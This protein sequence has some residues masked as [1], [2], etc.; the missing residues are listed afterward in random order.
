LLL[1]CFGCAVPEKNFNL[2]DAELSEDLR[3]LPQDLRVYVQ[4]SAE[5]SSREVAEYS[6]AALM[7]P[8]RQKREVERARANLF[9]PWVTPAKPLFQGE[10][11]EFFLSGKSLTPQA[12]MWGLFSLKPEKGFAEN[13]R[14]YPADRWE[15][16]RENSAGESFPNSSI[17]AITVRRCDLRLMPTETPY[18]FDPA[19]AGQGYPFDFYQNSTLPLGAPVRVIHLSKDEQWGLVEHSS[20]MGWA[21]LSNLA[22]VDGHFMAAWMD[23]PLAA[24]LREKTPIG[25]RSAG[26]SKASSENSGSLPLVEEAGI[27]ALLPYSISDSKP[28]PCAFELPATASLRHSVAGS[29]SQSDSRTGP[30]VN[31]NYM[32]PS[33]QKQQDGGTITVYF[34]E[35]GADGKA[36]LRRCVLD[37]TEAAPWPVLLTRLNIAGLGNRMLG[38]PYGWGGY[39]GNRDCSSLLRD[40]FLPFGLWL[41]RNS[42]AQAEYG[43]VT[44][45]S[46]LTAGAKE[47]AILHQGR[48]FLSLIGL[49]G[50]IAL[51]VGR[52]KNRA[53]I[54]HALWGLRTAQRRSVFGPQRS[55][56]LIIGKTVVTTVT[57]GAEKENIATPQSL[58]DLVNSMNYL[59]PEEE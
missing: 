1:V 28:H 9:A 12:A 58:L 11:P 31:R 52:Y 57:P 7:T 53:V 45:L 34:P 10:T 22:E 46:G 26:Q 29:D 5:F 25:R 40:L 49:P 38:Q 41:P 8:E 51:Y 6:Q 36:L 16:L 42:S 20:A 23:K 3:L 47:Q 43:K 37:E 13:L 35:R 30:I 14:P 24:V 48:P 55:G 32:P 54:F 33:A 2:S 18:F 19:Q 17:P 56:R 27:G 21:R 59:L 4:S 15:Y 50:H 44:K 39:E